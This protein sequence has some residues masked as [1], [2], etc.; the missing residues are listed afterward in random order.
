VR[1]FEVQLFSQILL[2]LDI[3]D[4]TAFCFRPSSG[5]REREMYFLLKTKE[6]CKCNLSS[7]LRFCLWLSPSLNLVRLILF[8]L[9]M[10]LEVYER[11]GKREEKICFEAPISGSN[12]ALNRKDMPVLSG[13]GK[14]C[15]KCRQENSPS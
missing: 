1:K 2:G 9:F 8:D 13:R 7:Q 14:Y 4:S 5:K 6:Q 11:T 15:V 12:A 10:F 3:S